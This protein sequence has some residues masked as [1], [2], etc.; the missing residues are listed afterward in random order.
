MKL[1]HSS[2][3]SS[4]NGNDYHEDDF[5]ALTSLKGLVNPPELQAYISLSEFEKARFNRQKRQQ[6]SVS[7]KMKRLSQVSTFHKLR[8]LWSVEVHNESA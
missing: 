7:R 5:A 2:K 4:N 8:H 1:S 6:F 3:Y